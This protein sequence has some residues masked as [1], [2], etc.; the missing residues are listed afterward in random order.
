MPVGKLFPNE[1]DCLLK[2][3]NLVTDA[4]KRRGLRSFREIKEEAGELGPRLL[5]SA[6]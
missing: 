6:S 5:G 1:E 4:V 3:G 2:L